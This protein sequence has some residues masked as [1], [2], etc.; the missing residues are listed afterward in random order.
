VIF[1]PFVDQTRRIAVNPNGVPDVCFRKEDITSRLGPGSYTE[2][3]LKT[4]SQYGEETIFYVT[5]PAAPS[6]PPSPR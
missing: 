3:T 2:E 5:Y 4:Q 6:G 1:T